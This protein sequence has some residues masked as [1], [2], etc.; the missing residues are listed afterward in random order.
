MR[1]AHPST[2]VPSSP[3]DSLRE[4]DCDG[5][6]DAG[7]APQLPVQSRDKAADSLGG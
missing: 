6:A 5:V 2:P 1:L 3:H 7:D 4:G